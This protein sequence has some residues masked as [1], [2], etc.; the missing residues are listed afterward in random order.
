MPH[1]HPPPLTRPHLLYLPNQIQP[2]RRQRPWFWLL[3]GQIPP[4]PRR[5]HTRMWTPCLPMLPHIYPAPPAPHHLPSPSPP[6]SPSSA[7]P[8]TTRDP[9]FPD[10]LGTDP[11]KTSR[12]V[13][14]GRCCMPVAQD[15]VG[16]GADATSS[17]HN[18]DRHKKSSSANAN[19]AASTVP[20]PPRPRR[21][22]RRPLASSPRRTPSSASPQSS[23]C[24]N[25]D[26]E[27]GK[28]G[29]SKFEETWSI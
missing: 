8:T 1:H 17:H 15:P 12:L 24:M 5:L 13:S 26:L 19:D 21:R 23:I 28:L 6:T 25:Q 18:R 20:S 7:P 22:P 11:V 9:P 29:N 4:S 14:K 16:A 27:A 2:A 10:E 3:S